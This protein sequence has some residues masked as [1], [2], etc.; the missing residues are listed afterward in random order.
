M[1]REP[2]RVRTRPGAAGA[3]AGGHP[4]G[5][6]TR[7][8]GGA[9]WLS[10]QLLLSAGMEDLTAMVLC[11]G[12]GTRLRPLTERLPKPA[13]PLCDVPLVAWTLALLRGAGVRRAV[14]NTHH[15]PGA[16]E[17]AA[18]EAG[19]GL[20]VRVEISHEPAIAGTGGALREARALLRG[21]GPLVLVNGDV[22]FDLDL[23]A[24]L[25]AHRSSGAL[26]T[27]VLLP[28][29]SGVRYAS[30]ELDAGGAVRRIAGAFG[31]GG[32]ALV[33]WH[34]SGVHV[35]SPEILDHL[36][37]EPFEADVNRHVYP[38]L[39]A[40]GRIRGHLAAG[41]W[42]DLG[43]PR[44]YLEAT[45]D[46]LEGRVPLGRFAGA[47]PLSGAVR[48]SEGLWAGPGAEVAPGARL[49]GPSYLGPGAR[50]EPGAEV[51]P[52][53]VVGSG[54]VVPHG[55]AVVRAVVW[56]GT[57]LRPGERVEDAVAAGELRVRG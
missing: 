24:A 23:G 36:P 35:L 49:T 37:T 39:M 19:R 29:P 42:N 6:A 9:R 1:R 50:V 8:V 44:R 40:G 45:R 57:V 32:G 18:R 47:E 30:V 48:P 31:P 22:L 56:P 16:M 43:T 25:A 5:S 3:V 26:A 14:V 20:G 2:K 28:M 17:A 53:A 52:A 15:R 55:A 27:M 34:F 54:A 38:P 41:Y 13:V 46:V 12:L 33:P 4:D 10:R 11:A 7:R 21:G 51:G